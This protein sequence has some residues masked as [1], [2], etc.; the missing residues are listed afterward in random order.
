MDSKQRRLPVLAACGIV[1]AISV[2]MLSGAG[3]EPRAILDTAPTTSSGLATGLP[4]VRV[5]THV[6]REIS[7]EV[8]LSGR[9]EPDRRVELRAEAEGRVVR[10]A[11]AR[12]EPVA[13]GTVVVELDGRDRLARLAE[14]ASLV[15]QREIEH[16]AIGN[17]R[18]QQFTTE[19]QIAEAAAQLESARAAH[20]RIKLEIANSTIT[21]PF[22]GVLQERLVEVGDFVR[23][24]DSIAELVDLD[25]LVIS[26]NVN[27]RE[28]GHVTLG[29][30][31]RAV[32]VDGT[33]LSG[34][35]RYVSRV[36]DAGTRTFHVELAVPNPGHSIRAGLTAQLRLL[37]DAVRVHTL[38]AA[39]LSLADDGTVG[40]KVVDEQDRVR[41]HPVQIVGSAADGMHVTGLPDQVRLIVVGQG[42]V[43][44]GQQVLAQPLA[45]E[46]VQP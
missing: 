10:I 13:A 44:E 12:G 11:A 34:T 1:V 4:Q 22:D 29:S 36:A 46:G 27:E 15:R 32:L 35:V 2:W 24:G 45:P 31:G 43:T 14:A 23:V 28:I 19:V 7:R 20:E 38:S 21:A 39:L 41:F 26:G 3:S 9:T 40:V 25:P 37:A 16:Q 33:A 5:A 30:E 8:L 6:A 42:F 17:L 18:N